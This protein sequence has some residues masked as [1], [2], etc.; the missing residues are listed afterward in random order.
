MGGG[1]KGRGKKTEQ[2]SDDSESTCSELSSQHEEFDNAADEWQEL[3]DNEVT[4]LDLFSEQRFETSREAFGHM[5][6]K[7]GL[8]VSAV[9]E[10]F[11]NFALNRES[12]NF[13]MYHWIRF[14]NYMRKKGPEEATCFWENRM[15]SIYLCEF[16]D[17]D[18]YLIPVLQEGDPLLFDV[19]EC[20]FQDEAIDGETVDKVVMETLKEKEALDP[21]VLA[22]LEELRNA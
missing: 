22:V 15:K 4:V 7:Y 12:N 20:E 5:E 14:V 21:E 17:D 1:K 16:F 13:E 11:K 8:K 10:L 3:D 6:E 2:Y 9:K 19:D 18:H